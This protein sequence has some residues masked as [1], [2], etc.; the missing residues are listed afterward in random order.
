MNKHDNKALE[1]LDDLYSDCKKE[2]G[3]IE[4]NSPLAKRY[5]TIRQGLQPQ[6]QDISTAPRDGTPV[7]I[8]DG[9][10][11]IEAKY[12]IDWQDPMY[13]EWSY[14][15]RLDSPPIKWMPLPTPPSEGE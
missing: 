12:R 6:W 8:T 5:R 4:E 15:E 9:T 2:Y 3:H 1:A 11:V 7:L 13:D 10:N 14:R